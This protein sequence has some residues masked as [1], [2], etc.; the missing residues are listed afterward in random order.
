MNS[1]NTRQWLTALSVS[2][3]GVMATMDSFILFI[4]TPEFLGVFSATISE[5]SWISTS[6]S[7]STMF[8]ML[9]SKWLV[10]VYGTKR[11]YN[12][13]LFLFILGSFLCSLSE[14]LYSLI[15]NR[16]IQ[17]AGAG[18]LLPVEGIV[19]RR[20]FP[21]EK[22]GLVFG[23]YGTTIMMGPALGPIIGGYI[24]D[25]QDWSWIFLVNIP[26]GLVCIILV[27]KY[28]PNDRNKTIKITKFKDINGAFIL[29]IAIVSLLTLLERGDRYFWFED[30]YNIL[31][32]LLGSFSFCYFIAHELETDVPLID[33][34]VFNNT[35]FALTIALYFIIQFIIAA[36]LYLLPL[37]MQNLLG[38]SASQAGAAL[39]PRAIVM[40]LFFPIVG[41]LFNKLGAKVLILS[42]LILC[43]YSAMLMSLLTF[44]AGLSDMLLPQA[45]QGLGIALMLSP[46]ITV[47]MQSLEKD[48]LSSAS[49]IEQSVRQLG[50]S[51]GIAMATSALTHLE[52]VNWGGLR[53][54]LD[55]SKVEFYKRFN[56]RVLDT[57]LD[58]TSSEHEALEK[59]YKVLSWRVEEQALTLS[60]SYIFQSITLLFLIAIIVLLFMKLERTN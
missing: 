34:R 39:A 58:T 15:F 44:D 49:A 19:L 55:F 25:N 51:F 50:V 1:V 18:L 14:E 11:T 22:H 27:D 17:G 47:A 16:I 8:F 23:I 9:L 5:I 41:L 32:A 48:K 6:Y 28:L 33:L 57:F 31:L 24:I 12:V 59:S 36:T 52:L 60:Y 53:H 20:T 35:T 21:I 38:F 26:I 45:I 10:D 7:V 13:G 43:T 2:I 30:S 54:Y 37:F 40:A 42:G 3:G 46:L 4:A 29:L 56:Y